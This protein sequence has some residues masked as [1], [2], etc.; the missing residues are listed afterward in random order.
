LVI[1]ESLWYAQ[2]SLDCEL[3]ICTSLHSH[4]TPQLVDMGV[5]QTFYWG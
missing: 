3:L 1:F 5:P 4:C 2:A